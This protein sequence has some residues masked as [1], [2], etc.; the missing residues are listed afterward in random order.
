MGTYAA[1]WRD[2]KQRL[3]YHFANGE[4]EGVC[5][6]WNDKGLLIAEMNYKEGHE[7]GPQKQYYNNGK[8]RANYTI[9]DGRRY[10]LLGTKNCVNV[11]DSVFKKF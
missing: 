5:R 3:L 11:T 10:G 1:W 6:D 4:Y 9:K 7:E 8:V 2:G